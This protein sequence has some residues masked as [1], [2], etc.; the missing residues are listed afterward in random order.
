MHACAHGVLHRSA[1]PELTF[2]YFVD[3][4][5]AGLLRIYITQFHVSCRICVG[6]PLVYDV[7]E[8]R[9]IL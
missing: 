7:R 6:R 5:P 9:V 3:G 2:T 4:I 1:L 8:T